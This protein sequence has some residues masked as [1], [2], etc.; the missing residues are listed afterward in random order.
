MILRSINAMLWCLILNM[1]E[2][3]IKSNWL[4]D[5]LLVKHLS[6]YLLCGCPHEFIQ[7]SNRKEGETRFYRIECKEDPMVAYLSLKIGHD[8]FPNQKIS[9][10]DIYANVQHPGMDGSF[11]HDGG[12]RTALYMVTSNNEGGEFE[13]KDGEGVIH[14]I[15][16]EQNKLIIFDSLAD[17]RG[18][19]FKKGPR[20]TLAWKIN[21]I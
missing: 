14:Q 3:I 10:D 18:L 2:I 6:Y 9:F 12:H 16:Y 19:S 15:K 11:H 5:P 8:F 17:H 20:L 1:N 21:E 4:E 13:Y 7:S